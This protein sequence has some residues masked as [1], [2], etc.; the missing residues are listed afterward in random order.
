MV[1]SLM[2]HPL[3]LMMLYPSSIPNK[4]QNR[5]ED[6]MNMEIDDELNDEIPDE[7]DFAN[8]KGGVRGKYAKQYH[9]GVK[10]IMLATK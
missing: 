10:F 2:K 9:E 5:R 6:F 1:F 7:Y 8:M 3:Y 4:Q